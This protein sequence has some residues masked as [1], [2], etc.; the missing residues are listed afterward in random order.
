MATLRDYI[1]FTH[2]KDAAEHIVIHIC[3]HPC[4]HGDHHESP[5]ARELV[6]ISAIAAS[7]LILL[8]PLMRRSSTAASDHDRD[9]C[10]QRSH[11]EG[12]RDRQSAEPHVGEA[13]PDHGIPLQHKAHAQQRRTQRNERA[14][15][16][17]ARTMKG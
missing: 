2:G 16:A 13:V 4:R 12:S 14:H 8:F 1:S 5:T 7:P 6:E 15:S 11:I 10:R 3:I 17:K 9:R